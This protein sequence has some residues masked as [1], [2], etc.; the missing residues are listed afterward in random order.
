MW[1]YSTVPGTKRTSGRLSF[2]INSQR[3]IGLH[4]I[5]SRRSQPKSRAAPIKRS[6]GAAS[7]SIRCPVF[8]MHKNQS[9]G[10]QHQS[11]KSR[12]RPPY[13]VFGIVA[14]GN[15]SKNRMI[16]DSQVSANL[17]KAAGFGNTFHEGVSAGWEN[18]RRSR[19][20][21]SPGE[22]VVSGAGF[23]FRLPRV[24]GGAGVR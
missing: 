20:L 5:A 1:P 11:F 4:S 9:P 24:P 12:L 7:S 22:G 17:M 2:R 15:I 21:R 23:P 8:R 19:V 10:S 3:G 18:S 14:M 13:P 6:S 16:I